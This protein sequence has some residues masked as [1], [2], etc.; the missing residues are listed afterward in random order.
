MYA[1]AQ[2]DQF[3]FARQIAVDFAEPRLAVQLL[4]QVLAL[5]VSQERQRSGNV[6]G[7]PP[8]FGNVGGV[9]RQLIGEIG[10]CRDNLLEDRDHVLAQ[11]FNFGRDFRLDV[12]QSLDAG[13]QEGLVGRELA[14]PY[15][16]DAF[17][18]EQQVVLGNLDGLVHHAQGADLKEI[19][20][21]GGL[22]ARVHLGNHGESTILPE[23]LNQRQRT[24]TSH[25]DRQKR[26]RVDDGVA[27]RED[28]K[29]FEDRVLLTS[30]TSAGALISG[31]ST[32]IGEYSQCSGRPLPR[33]GLPRTILRDEQARFAPAHDVQVSIAI[34][35]LHRDLH[36]AAHAV[37][38]SR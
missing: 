16:R 9:H 23:G 2:F 34:Q 10:R 20:G 22:H 33:T 6:I 32:G 36:P 8:R 19:L 27:Y 18:E 37:R 30:V 38:H 12:G 3:E 1:A 14:C 21:A 13:A 17:A 5:R 7:Q 25:R 35:I 11:G 24:G 26:A 15:A 4:Q 31:S 29:V 28:G